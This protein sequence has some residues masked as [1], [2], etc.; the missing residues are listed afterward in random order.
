MRR[1]AV[2]LTVGLAVWFG[3]AV[4]AEA[5]WIQPTGPLAVYAGSTSMT[6]TATVTVP[7]PANFCVKL[8][9]LKNGVE[10]YNSATSIPN[11]GTTT[12]YFS[13][14]LDAST[15]GL[16]AGNVLTFRVQLLYNRGTYNF[17]DYNLTVLATRPSKTY[18]KSPGLALQAGDRD[19]RRE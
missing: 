16:S 9:V 1:I 18:Q 12:Y 7:T 3:S 6:Y 10:M 19:R 8:W 11:P 13:N 17:P 2:G 4:A 14:L 15:W 5:Q